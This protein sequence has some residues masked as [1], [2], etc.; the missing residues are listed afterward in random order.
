LSGAREA[1]AQFGFELQESV[2]AGDTPMDR[3]LE[4]VGLGFHVGPLQLSFRARTETL[5]LDTPQELGH[6]LFEL[7]RLEPRA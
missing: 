7:A 2:G 6:A 4:G 1:A 3:F 5:R